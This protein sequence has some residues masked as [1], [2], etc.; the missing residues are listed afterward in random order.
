MTLGERIALARKKAGLSQEQ[1]G[2]RLG[3]S[4]QAVSKWESS[5]ANPDVAYVAE[6]CRICG[7]SC[8]WLLLGEEGAREAPPARCGSCGAIVTGLD[9]YC[10]QCGHPLQK[11]EADTYSLVLVDPRKNLTAAFDALA[12]LSRRP[13]CAPEFPIC[14]RSQEELEA[15]LFRAPVSLMWGLSAQRASEALAAFR[16]PG[17]AAVYRDSDGSSAEELV[18]KP[19]VP[20]SP[21]PA[22]SPAGLPCPSGPRWGRCF[23]GCWPPRWCSPCF[24]AGGRKQPKFLANGA[25]SLYTVLK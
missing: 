9:R 21:S 3:V 23:W 17:M 24:E 14:R 20:P 6:L 2:D 10:P 7:V 18:Q 12:W 22:R 4:R 25:G 16:T 15:L 13:W 8:D 1:L 5:Q 19:Q 11:E